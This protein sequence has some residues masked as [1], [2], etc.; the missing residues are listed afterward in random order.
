MTEN[1]EAAGCPVDIEEAE[2][3]ASEDVVAQRE[4]SLAKQ[5]AEMRS[6]K[7]KLVD[8]LQLEMNIAAEDLSGYKPSFGYEM[9]P[10]SDKQRATLEKFGRLT[11]W[12]LVI[13]AADSVSHLVLIPP[14]IKENS[15]WD[16]Y[17]I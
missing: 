16:S 17:L 6:R 15:I 7:R 5:L 2:K 4:E 12:P 11:V 1:I 3:K 10:P 14:L 9:A 13:K 8:P